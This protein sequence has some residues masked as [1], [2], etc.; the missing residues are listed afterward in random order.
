MGEEVALGGA[1][2]ERT[3]K[4]LTFGCS[5]DPGRAPGPTNHAITLKT[6]TLCGITRRGLAEGVPRI[7]C[8]RASGERSCP[9]SS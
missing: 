7:L 3:A 9:S 2:G 5:M 4:A 8:S 6:S 1:G